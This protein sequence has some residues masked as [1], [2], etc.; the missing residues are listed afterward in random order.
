[1]KKI[2]VLLALAVGLL[3]SPAHAGNLGPVAPGQGGGNP[4]KD[5][6]DG[7]DI[8]ETYQRGI[9]W[10]TPVYASWISGTSQSGVTL[11]GASS[12][13]V[14][15]YWVLWSVTSTARVAFTALTYLAQSNGTAVA[16]GYIVSGPASVILGPYPRSNFGHARSLTG[17]A[18][19]NYQIGWLE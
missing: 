9:R 4:Q 6:T 18:E 14:G 3:V 8:K 16:G 11:T 19:G 7:Q 5:A 2:L 15:P 1:M 12:T 17:P 10:S 13:Y